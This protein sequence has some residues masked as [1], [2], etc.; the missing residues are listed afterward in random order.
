AE[1]G[2][3]SV[4]CQASLDGWFAPRAN[5]RESMV[6]VLRGKL[7]GVIA[8]L[9]DRTDNWCSETGCHSDQG[10]PVRRELHAIDVAIDRDLREAVKV[11]ASGERIADARAKRHRPAAAVLGLGRRPGIAALTERVEL[12]DQR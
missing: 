11:G 9:V 12:Q 5:I 7:H 3:L 4:L 2:G 10:R 1:S 6:Q 8:S